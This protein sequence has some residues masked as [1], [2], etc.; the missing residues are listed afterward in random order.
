[1][2]KYRLYLKR[3]S[4]VNSGLARNKSGKFQPDLSFQAL[5]AA[6]PGFSPAVQYIAPAAQAMLGMADMTPSLLQGCLSPAGQRLPS[7]GPGH[8]LG[9]T[10]S[11]ASQLSSMV[12]PGIAS[13]DK[14]K[15]QDRAN[16][17]KAVRVKELMR[18]E[19]GEEVIGPGW[20]PP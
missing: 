16:F 12:M 6:N 10:S 13:M 8:P 11:L 20:E 4:G 5:M 19:E 1:M 14:H 3:L 18:E 15:F 7:L 9:G 17:G 2:Q